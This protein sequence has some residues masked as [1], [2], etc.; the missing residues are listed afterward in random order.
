[1]IVAS[2]MRKSSEKIS[3]APSME[4]LG[5]NF[6]GSR[7]WPT[8]ETYATISIPYAILRYFSATAPAATRP[9]VICL[10]MKNRKRESVCVYTPTVSRALLRP[11]P[12]LAFILYFSR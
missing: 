12:L 7:I 2:S 5:E 11:P 1:M 6:G 10:K 8:D 4:T 3:C 9:C